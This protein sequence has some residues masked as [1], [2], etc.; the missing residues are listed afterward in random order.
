MGDAPRHVYFSNRSA[1]HLSKGDAPAALADA[2]ACI[3]ANTTWP[4]GY[5]RKGAALH[6]LRRYE[7]AEQAYQAGLAVVRVWCWVLVLLLLGLAWFGCVDG[8]V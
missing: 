4:K 2:E 8:V 5:S 3:A 7:D 6:A 1:A